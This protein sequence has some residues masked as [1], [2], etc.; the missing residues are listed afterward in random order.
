MSLGGNIGALQLRAGGATRDFSTWQ[1][2]PLQLSLPIFDG[3]RIAA[4]QAAA[5]ARYDAAVANFQGQVRQAVQEVEPARPQGAAARAREADARAAVAG[6][7]QQFAAT[8]ALYRQGMANLPR[9]EEAR[10]NLLVSEITLAQLLNDQQA[11]GVALYRAAG[12]GWQVPARG[13]AP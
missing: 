11:A 13:A 3:G 5:R 8:E 1:F 6:Y 4:G 7:R 2:G 12:G 10:R 9:L